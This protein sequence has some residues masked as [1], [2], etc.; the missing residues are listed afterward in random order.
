MQAK[1][2][3]SFDELDSALKRDFGCG[4]DERVEVVGHDD[5]VVQQIFGL[6]TIS[7]ESFEE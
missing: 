2:K 5:E 7:E 1:R 6:I 3:S 4:G